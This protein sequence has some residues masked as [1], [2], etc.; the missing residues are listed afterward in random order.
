M[1]G[2]HAGS[3]SIERAFAD[4]AESDVAG[5]AGFLHPEVESRVFPPLLNTGT[6]QGP[7]GSSR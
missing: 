7:T 4:F 3:S 2:G 5:L 6:W 1:S